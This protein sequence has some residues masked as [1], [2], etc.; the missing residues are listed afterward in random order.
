MTKE[1]TDSER[2]AIE[3]GAEALWQRDH[4]T[5]TWPPFERFANLYRDDARAVLRAAG[6]LQNR[7]DKVD[8]TT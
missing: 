5:E 8:E 1:L 6:C 4:K 2:A 3:R 7:T